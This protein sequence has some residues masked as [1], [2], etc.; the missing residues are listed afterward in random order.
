M[1]RVSALTSRLAL[2]CDHSLPDVISALPDK[3]HGFARACQPEE[4]S[5]PP[6]LRT[7]QGLR[8]LNR[9]IRQESAHAHDNLDQMGLQSKMACG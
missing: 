4:N 6:A 1:G 3:I 9:V 7:L 2:I 5:L 8:F